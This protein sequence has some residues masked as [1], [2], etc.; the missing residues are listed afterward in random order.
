MQRRLN[1]KV[2][3]W[4]V[5]VVAACS[6]GISI[7]HANQVRRH[8]HV[9][10]ERGDQAWAKGDFAQAL[11]YFGQYLTLAP[12]DEDALEKFALALDHTARDPA[13]HTRVVLRLEDL[14]MRDGKRQE[15]RYR[16]VHNLIKLHRYPDAVVHLNALLPQRPDDA[17]LHQLLGQCQAAI[18]DAA[19]AAGSLSHAIELDPARI[20]VYLMLAD[21]QWRGLAQEEEAV[22]TVDRMVQANSKKAEAYLA[23]GRFAQQR[24][25]L[26]NASIDVQQ[27]IALAPDDPTVSLAA[28]SWA[29]S[30]GRVDEARRHLRRALA[31][32]PEHVGLINSL[33]NLELRDGRRAETIRILKD[34]IAKAPDAFELQILLADLL[35]DDKQLDAA[36][37]LIATMVRAGLPPTFPDY[38]QGRLAVERGQ[39]SKAIELLEK[40]AIVLG[41]QTEWSS[42]VNAMLGR[43]YAEIGAHDQR[44]VAWRRAVDHEPNWT[45]ARHG[46]GAALL[47]LGRL[48]DALAELEAASKAS[49]AS[50]AVWTALAHAQLQF[51][52]RRPQAGR[53]WAALEQSLAKASQMNGDLVQITLLHAEML[54]A[55]GDNLAARKLLQA[56]AETTNSA[57]CWAAL[58][59]LDARQGRVEAGFKTLDQA[60]RRCGD[61][62]ELRLSRVRLLASRG[63]ADDRESLKLLAQKLEALPLESRVNVLR[64]LADAWRQLGEFALAESLWRQIAQLRPADRDSRFL[65]LEAALGRTDAEAAR[66]L[67]AELRRLEGD[68]GAL[69]RFGDAALKIQEAQG[70]AAKLNLIRA[71]LADLARRR[72]DWPRIPLLEA[73][74]DEIEGKWEQVIENGVKAVELGERQP[75][76]LRRLMQLL[77]ERRLYPQAE[78]VLFLIEEQAP[79]PPDLA[80]DAAD[81]AAWQNNAPRARQLAAQLFPSAPRD[82]RDLLWLAELHERIGE[83]TQ[84]EAIFRKAVER[85][86][87]VPDTW[88]L[89]VEHLARFGKHAAAG[90]VIEQMQ[91]KMPRQ[92]LALTLA[93]CQDAA[94][95][96]TRAAAAYALALADHPQDFAI[97]AA[98]ADFH[99][100]ADQPVLAATFLERLLD[101]AAAAPPEVTARARRRLSMC[102]WAAGNPSE[103]LALVATNRQAMGEQIADRRIVWFLEGQDA[104]RR[105]PA[106]QRLQESF[107]R[108][109]SQAEEELLLVRLDEAGGD[110]ERARERMAQLLRT[111]ES[112]QWIAWHVRLLL[113]AEAIDEALTW[114][115]KLERWEPT[116]PRTRELKDLLLISK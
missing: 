52:L 94:G 55:R 22:K 24:G 86:E 67:V 99:W 57:A 60:E 25:Q 87:H 4:T 42:R 112:P 70:S 51:E 13:E 7:L 84:A 49:D 33:A 74:I 69:W 37:E 18:G 34:G 44:L 110:A 71:D 20:A 64:A 66:R 23:R 10:L 104:A 38:L 32:H 27:A 103:A 80:R 59:D 1:L 62:V 56:T 35:I 95:D 30:Q 12:G 58:A 65:L 79:L 88:V 47:A 45:A 92:R 19:A 26:T 46:M 14:L 76:F 6:I 28:A 73:R 102:R 106:V 91:K 5:A 36:Q 85:A 53:A 89:L 39:W 29:E 101:P 105:Q 63:N 72:P 97:L 107:T 77:L 82:Y 93:R 61:V 41:N 75:R 2:F 113:K 96:W 15:A 54:A 8:A 50:A 98:A 68:Q 100:R 40:A 43:C 83:P 108:F 17:E 21:V 109:P 16:L 81:V 78:Q 31:N 116:S 3:F 114:F 9:I 115:T 11:G 90:A 48:D 111:Q